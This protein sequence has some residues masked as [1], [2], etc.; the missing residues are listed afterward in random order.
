MIISVLNMTHVLSFASGTA[1]LHYR[2]QE[3]YVFTRACLFVGFSAELLNNFWMNFHETWMD[4]VS[5]PGID[6]INFGCGSG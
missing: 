1:G 4:D 6:P 5:Q 2:H 3:G